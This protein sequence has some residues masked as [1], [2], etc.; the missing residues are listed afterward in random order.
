VRRV[1]SAH[2]AALSCAAAATPVEVVYAKQSLGAGDAGYGLV[3]AFW[4]IG[5]VCSSLALTRARDASALRLIP[6]GA[7][8]AGVA[9]LVMAAA[10]AL[11]LGLAGCFLGGAGNGVY[12]VSV[13][14]ALQ[15]RIPDDLQA[16][17]MS[18]LESTTAGAY[19]VGF[20]AGGAIAAAADARLALGLAGAGVLV[21][22]AA[23]VAL[24]RGDRRVSP[25]RPAALAQQPEPAR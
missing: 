7:G 9:F 20:L 8:A 18:L 10:P 22:A 14:Q 17:V 6:L 5:T 19:G 11:W 13:V 21:A 12:Y 1:L 24:L 16:R 25:A 15:E 3:L 2:A 23:I 4:G